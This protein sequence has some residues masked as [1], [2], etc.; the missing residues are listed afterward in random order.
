MSELFRNWMPYPTDA[1]VGMVGL[2]CVAA[3]LF[4]S[5]RDA[6]GV[7]ALFTSALLLIAGFSLCLASLVS[8]RCKLFGYVGVASI[9]LYLS[10]ALTT[11]LLVAGGF[12]N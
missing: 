12:A 1:P 8:E 9:F 4:L 3:L 11:T 2:A 7:A 10:S 5:V 6:D